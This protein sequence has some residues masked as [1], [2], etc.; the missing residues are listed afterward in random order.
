MLQQRM[1]ERF[2][3]ACREDERVVGALM[4]GSFAVGEGD[5]F[6]DIE[7]AVFIRD[8]AFEGFGQR[9]WLGEI[10]PVAA[11]FA[12]DFGHQTALFQ[13]GVRGEFHFMR[14]SDVP[15]IASWRGNGWFPSLAAAVVLDRSGELS[16]HA[17]ALVGGP[18]ARGGAPLAEGLAL[19]LLNLMLF[20]ANLLNRGEFARAWA[21]LG[22][23]HDKLLKLVRLHEGATAHWPTPSRAL[24]KDISVDAYERY[25][26]CT[27]GAQPAA[28]CAAYRES[29]AWSRELFGAVAGPLN[30]ELPATVMARV[31]KLLDEAFTRWNVS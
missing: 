9:S 31:E 16:Q 30:V 10:S 15:V 29:W 26:T 18:P 25:V 3:E 4:Y 20:G 2:R 5:A 14:A 22:T 12:D 28:L 19:N 8:D 6:S 1:I 27:A 21:L 23:A 13:N 11:Y 24:E 17:R 7:F